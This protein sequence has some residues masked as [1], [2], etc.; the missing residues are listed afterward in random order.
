VRARDAAPHRPGAA[1]GQALVE[2]TLLV[3]VFL[4]VLVGMI[5]FGLVFTHAITIEYATREGSRAAA[6]LSNGGGTLGCGAGQSPNWS[7]VDPLVI[8]AVERVLESPG[9]QVVTANVSSIVIYKADPASGNAGN[10]IANTSNTW[11]YAPGTGPIPAGTTAHLNFN[12]ASYPNSDPWKACARVNGGATID[13]VGVSVTYTYQF[14]TPLA[15][16]MRLMGGTGVG[17][18][19]ITD[20]TVM[21]LNPSGS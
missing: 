19:T 1:R 5:E 21:A 10:P 8:A 11:T 15:G 2:F 12:N 7:T 13:Y 14:Q 16:I 4:L 18:L 17:S 9:S 6:A 3:P 20:R